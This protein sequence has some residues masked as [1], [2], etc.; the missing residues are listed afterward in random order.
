MRA[1]IRALGRG[2]AAA[3]TPSRGIKSCGHAILS[4]PLGTLGDGDVKYC[5]RG[6]TGDMEVRLGRCGQ[7]R[8]LLRLKM[9]PSRLSMSTTTSASASAPVVGSAANAV[10][11]KVAESGGT[12]DNSDFFISRFIIG[13]EER[14]G[15]KQDQ[16]RKHEVGILNRYKKII[17]TLDDLLEL[18]EGD[19]FIVWLG[20]QGEWHGVE[21][22][23]DE[24]EQAMGVDN[25]AE[26]ANL[27]SGLTGLE[28]EDVLGF[29]SSAQWKLDSL[30]TGKELLF[31]AVE[32]EEEKE[33]DERDLY[34]VKLVAHRAMLHSCLVM[35]REDLNK[36]YLKPTL[37]VEEVAKAIQAAYLAGPYDRLRAMFPLYDKHGDGLLDEQGA[38][39]AVD[40]VTL[41]MVAAVERLFEAGPRITLGKKGG[42]T[43]AHTMKWALWDV[44]EVPVKKR[45][46]F[47]WAEG[48]KQVGPEEWRVSWEQFALSVKDHFP[49]LQQTTSKYMGE[50]IKRRVAWHE[51][52][53]SRRRAAVYGA[54]LLTVV[55]A[56]DYA[57]M[58]V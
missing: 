29:L 7:P 16:I 39:H 21:Q 49:E 31:R 37:S 42:R 5:R 19:E 34:Q 35:L 53:K 10:R 46:A 17:V 38:A 36:G 50:Y 24:H 13:V 58:A 54:A 33:G 14:L 51:K 47:S 44:M 25:D 30:I 48:R 56:A 12:D 22:T 2:I 45:C 28:K 18:Q 11:D 4:P 26:S 3:G 41:P 20:D 9:N 52:R 27:H 8:S 55:V 23:V 43:M 40:A 57:S 6:G 32:G 1:R 15:A